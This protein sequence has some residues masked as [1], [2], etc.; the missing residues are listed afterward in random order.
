MSPQW[1]SVTIKALVIEMFLKRAPPLSPEVSPKP[2][3]A[4]LRVLMPQPRTPALSLP[5]GAWPAVWPEAG[6]AGQAGSAGTGSA[7][8]PRLSP[9][10]SARSLRAS[11][12]AAWGPGATRPAPG[13]TGRI[14]TA[15]R[16]LCVLASL[17]REAVT[18]S[19]AS[20]T[21]ISKEF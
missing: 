3:G 21:S 17:E 2:L 4:D 14:V 12:A 8:V 10:T 19:C 11:Q 6:T 1:S 7:S 15:A 5:E 16:Q 20:T 9:A 18:K 13:A